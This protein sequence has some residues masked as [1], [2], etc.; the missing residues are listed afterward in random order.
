MPAIAEQLRSA[1]SSQQ[2]GCWTD[3]E[4]FYRDVLAK[5]PDHPDAVHLLGMAAQQAGRIEEAMALLRR[6]VALDSKAPH[7]HNNLG[8]ALARCGKEEEAVA[9]FREAIRL[10][11]GNRIKGDGE[12]SAQS[13]FRLV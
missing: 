12:K 3:A 13:V 7:F 4:K 11:G 8:N 1:L 9:C 2:R 5:E 10:R 6:A